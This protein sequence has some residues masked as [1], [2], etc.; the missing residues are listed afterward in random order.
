MG[1]RAAIYCRVST[2]DQ[3]CARQERDLTAFAARAG[4][5]VVG[6]YKE[7]GSG[8][9]L[10]RLERKRVMALA[11]ARAIDVVLVIELSR[12]GR[13]TLDLLHNTQRAG[14]SA[15]LGD[16]PE[17]PVER[18]PPCPV[19]TTSLAGPLAAAAEVL[20]VQSAPS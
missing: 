9:R 17:R 3:S 8:V 13:G 2:A 20:S 14:E 15:G 11:Q 19:P 16:R 5:E 1:Q 7:T 10:D 4:Y 12:W 6:V 18:Q